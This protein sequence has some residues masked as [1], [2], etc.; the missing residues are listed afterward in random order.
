MSA[1]HA[2][3]ARQLGVARG[4]EEESV[5]AGTVNASESMGGRRV[6]QRQCE[7]TYIP[8]LPAPNGSVA[9]KARGWSEHTKAQSWWHEWKG[10]K[11]MVESKSRGS[12]GSRK[13]L[14]TDRN[15]GMHKMAR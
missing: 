2:R 9:A 7:Q 3:H 13:V 4:A 5:N 11:R 6:N 14:G 12:G 15:N 1:L 10:K 8:S